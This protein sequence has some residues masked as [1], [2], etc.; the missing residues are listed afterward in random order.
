MVMK[1]S[2]SVNTSGWCSI[3]DLCWILQEKSFVLVIVYGAFGIFYGRDNVPPFPL[4][5]LYAFATE[6]WAW[7]FSP[8]SVN[9]VLILFGTRAYPSAEICTAFFQQKTWINKLRLFERKFSRY[10]RDRNQLFCVSLARSI[11]A[12]PCLAIEIEPMFSLFKFPACC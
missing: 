9:T 1:R 5:T 11:A 6:T 4:S 12:A 8:S 10:Y 7:W 2:I 3:D